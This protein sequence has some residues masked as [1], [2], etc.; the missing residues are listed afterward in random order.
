[1]CSSGKGFAWACSLAVIPPRVRD[2]D[3][4][5]VAEPVPEAEELERATEAHSIAVGFCGDLGLPLPPPRLLGFRQAC[6]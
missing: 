3:V 5:D 4:A 2:P 6:P 1:M